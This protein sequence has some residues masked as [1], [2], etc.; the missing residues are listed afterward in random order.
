MK[1]INI[2]QYVFFTWCWACFLYTH[3]CLTVMAHRI[4]VPRELKI[5]VIIAILQAYFD[6]VGLKQTM[7]MLHL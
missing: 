5:I 1:Y 3:L 7:F 2:L 4:P 6:C